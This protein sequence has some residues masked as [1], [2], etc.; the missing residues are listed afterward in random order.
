MMLQVHAMA[1][2]RVEKV[3]EYVVALERLN[4]ISLCAVPKP[5]EQITEGR[6]E[7]INHKKQGQRAHRRRYTDKPYLVGTGI[8]EL[9]REDG[10]VMLLRESAKHGQMTAPEWIIARYFVVE[11]GDARGRISFREASTD[12]IYRGAS[13]G[14]VRTPFL[15][16]GDAQAGI[17][18]IFSRPYGTGWFLPRTDVLGNL[19]VFQR[20][21]AA[22]VVRHSTKERGR[23]K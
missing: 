12:K 21:E 10:K 9:D 11:D 17:L 5:V 16:S 4:E 3:A 14:C 18:V 1:K 22:P 15:K 13:R 23:L 19:R 7:L 6:D 2:V 20:G 8:F